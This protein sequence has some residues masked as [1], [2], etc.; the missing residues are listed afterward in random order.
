M[1]FTGCPYSGKLEMQIQIPYLCRVSVHE[2]SVD[3]LHA[4]VNILKL[5][6]S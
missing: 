1:Q 3:A 5:S 6:S 4:N 2:W